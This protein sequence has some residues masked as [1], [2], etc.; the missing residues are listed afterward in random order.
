MISD[1]IYVYCNI[2]RISNKNG[3]N[4]FVLLEFKNCINNKLTLSTTSSIYKQTIHHYLHS[5]QYILLVVL[6]LFVE[7]DILLVCS[8]WS[9]LLLLHTSDFS[10]NFSGSKARCRAKVLLRGRKN[11]WLGHHQRYV[12]PDRV[13][14]HRRTRCHRAKP[15]STT[16]HSATTT[17]PYTHSADLKP[18][19][20]AVQESRS[21][22]FLNSLQK[23]MFFGKT[24]KE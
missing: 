13:P 19:K 24:F 6:I 4:T 22:I 2:L 20:G 12:V 3:K 17:I 23:S 5:K 14:I 21:T 15:A 18:K 16:S 8:Q 9:G 10:V 1:I 7:L 11:M